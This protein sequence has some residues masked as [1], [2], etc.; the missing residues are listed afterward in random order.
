MNKSTRTSTW[1]RY[2]AAVAIA[3]TL[4]GCATT[5]TNPNDPLE[6]FNRAMFQFNDGLDNVVLKPAGEAYRT[7][8]PS[9]VRTGVK[10]FFSNVEDLWIGVN[11]LLQG[12]VEEGLTDFMRVAVNTFFGFTVIDVASDAGMTKHNED[13]G[14]TLGRWGVG[15]GPYVV[16]PFFGSSTFRDGVGLAFDF[17]ADPVVN[18]GHVPTRNTLYSVR[19]I[20]ERA[21]LLDASRILEEAALDKYGFTRDSYLQRRRSLIYDGNPP[22]EERPVNNDAR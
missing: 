11:N 13:F 18:V 3:A 15:S 19:V 20:S 5:A 9:L 22:R 14:Q 17:Q 7:V 10:N 21:N 2:G 16:L 4:A 1:K 8:I 12:K 6:P